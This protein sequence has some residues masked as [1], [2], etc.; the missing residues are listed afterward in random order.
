M[1][2]LNLD[3]YT[4]KDH[5]SDGDIEETLLKMAQEGKSFEDLPE[6]EVSFPMVYHFS[7]LR[8]NILSWYPLKKADSV[9]EIGAGCGAITGMLCRKAGHVTSVELSKR[10]ADINYARNRDKENLTIMVGNLNDMTFPEKFDYVVVNGVLEYAMSF[11]EGKTPYETFLQ[12]MGAY[13]KPEGRLLIAI[14][15][16]LGLKYFAGAPE[17]HTDLHFFGINGYPGNQSVRTFSKNE[18]GELLENSGFPFLRFYY[19][20]PDYKFPTEIFTDE[21]LYT[22][23]Y[24]RSYPVYTDKTADLFAESEGVKAFEKEKI[25]DSFVNSFLVEA[26]RTE[27]RDPEEILYVKL[28]QERKEKFRLLTRIVRENGEVRAEK[29]AMVPQA[30]EFVE[31]LKK[32]GTESTGSDKYKNLP[33]RAENGKISY[34]LLTGKTL[35]QEIAELAQKEDLEE[36]KALL[37]KFYQE[38]FGARQVVDYRTGEFREVFGDH[39]GREDYECVCPANVDLICSNIFMGEKENQIIDY[40]WMFD[41]PV[42]VNFIMWRLIHELYTHISELPWLCHEDEMMAEFDISYTDYEI[43]MDWTMHFVYEYVGCGSLIPFEQKK[44]PVSVTELVN[45][46]REKHQMHSKLYY[47]LGEGFCEEHTLYADGKLSGNRFRVEF[48]LSGIKGI[49]NLRWNPANGHFLKVRIERLDCGCS[50][51]LVPQGVHMKVDNSTTAFFTTDGFYLIDVTHPENVD[52]IVIEGKLDCLELPD[53]E[54]LLAFEKEREVRR[55]QER[56]RKEAERAAK[57]AAEE[58]A[59]A[60]EEALRHPGKKAQVKRLVKKVLRYHTEPAAVMG[61]ETTP[62]CMGSVDFFHY[63][64]GTLNAIGWAFDPTFA[65]MGQPRI[66]FYQGTQKLQEAS[67][68]TIYRTDVANAI[69]NPDAE[70]AGFSFLATVLAPAET[71][72]FLEYGTAADTGRFLIGK[73]PGT[74]DQKEL[75]V[76]AIEDPK[77]IGNLRHFKQRHVRSTRKA[78][79]QAVYQQKVDVIVPVYN[80]LEYF[81]ALFSGIEKTKVPYRLIIVNDKSPDPEVGNYLEKYAA[82]HDNVVLLN[83]ETNMGFLPSVNRGLKMAENH[84]ALVNTD[85]EV[86]EEWLERLMLPIFAKENIATTTP[87]TT[88][89]TICSFPDFCRDNKLF[90][91]MPLWEI[92]DEFRMIRPQ[93]PAMPTGVGF[94]MGMNLKAIQEVGLLDEENFGKGYGEENDWCQRAIAAGY[95]NVHV[96]NLFVYHK[97]GGSFPSE[98]KQRLLKEHSEALLRKHPDYNKDTADYCRRDPLRPV[99]LYVEMKLLNRK[100]DVPTIVAFD[101]DLG[102]GATAYL[103]EKRRLALREGYRFVTIRYNIVSNRFYFTYQYKQYEME[104]FANDLETALGELMRVDEIWINELVTYQ[105]IYGTLERILRLKREQGAKLLMLLHDF[106][107]LCPAVN[108]I[109]AEGKYCGVP[110]CEVCDKCIP[111]NRSNACTEYGTGTL[112]RTKFREFLSNCDE[113]RAFSD[114]TA[115]LFKRAYPDVYNLHVIPH[116]PH[117]LPAVKKNKKTTE[118][119]NIGL[120]GVLCYKKGLEV[121]KALAGYIEENELN[122]RLRLIGTSDEE[123][124]SPVFSQTGRYTR[125]EIPRLTLE[126]DI[127]MFLIPSVWPETFSYTTSEIISMGFPVAVLPVGAPVERVKRYAKGLVLKDEKPENIV[128]EMISLWKTLGESELPVEKRR[129]LFVGEEISFASRYRVEHF[130]EQ[131]ILKGYASKFIQIDQAE[132]EKIEEYTAIVMYRCSKLME[133]ELLANR[134]K[135]AGIPVYYD[136]DDLVFNYEKISGLHFLKGSEYSDFRTTTDRIRGCMGFCDGYFTSTETLAGEIREEFPEKPVVI[137]RNCM[138]MEMEILSHEAVEQTDKAKDRIY[139]GYLSGSKTHD[140]DFAQVEAALLEVME[141]HPEV[142]LKLVGV[143]DESGMEPVQNRIEKL[144]FMDWRQL[145]AV[146]AG[147]DIN[148]MPLENSLFHWCKSENKWT[149]AALVK[150]PSVMSRNCEME[151][152]VEN[153]KDGWMC[154]TKEEWVNVLEALVTDEKARK[155]MGEAAHQKVME[156]YLTVNTGKDAM[157]ELLCN[158]SYTK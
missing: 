70:S 142:Y 20:Y 139:I 17:D 92:D 56:V 115:R 121:V 137:N 10:R 52:R 64:N 103:V 62:T 87:F 18:L 144:P 120:I 97:H 54:K 127:D 14:E 47:D 84:V 60:Q 27:N 61:V 105:N 122:I 16:R 86:P 81:D 134:A 45:R 29:E 155:A 37:K 129:L 93:Y 108:L 77:S 98:E 53:V 82:E 46:E 2:E 118:T 58:A 33:C 38:F 152:V 106:F 117:Y 104:F 49:R 13:L 125:E 28:N 24:G 116:A 94:C 150:V 12:R 76:Y 6:E 102:G 123:I 59:R 25:L 21:S 140:Q 71:S 119:F 107:A 57:Q 128:E 26:G 83:N 73:I 41:F 11:T 8:E 96:D 31:K 68:T 78:Y 3:Y 30:E 114:D 22:N 80:G 151:Y 75:L 136:V 95:E 157:E 42:P 111:D 156:H 101:H 15:N 90:E 50:A 146:I 85:V 9:L 35:H 44:V 67:C 23:S 110:S 149:E 43:F 34:P 36:I 143:L 72:V 109:D 39:P 51:E 153:G 133:A 4:A 89:G 148:L 154:T 79:P 65:S 124:E 19:P 88:C 55:E 130:R 141:R 100:L 99:R 91:G 69:G 112:W 145:P 126:Q 32:T 40:E 138:S 74:R 5:Y 48:A 66:V 113:I 147:L 158:E 63:E 1:A 131:L 135:A 7:G 132:Q